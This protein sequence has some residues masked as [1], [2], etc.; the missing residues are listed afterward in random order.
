[1]YPCEWLI[2]I[3]ACLMRVAHTSQTVGGLLIGYSGLDIHFGE[4]VILNIKQN[5]N[6]VQIIFEHS[7]E[8]HFD[9]IIFESQ[10]VRLAFRNLHPHVSV[11]RCH[12]KLQLRNAWLMVEITQTLNHEFPERA[13]CES[14]A[15][16]LW[17]LCE[18]SVSLLW[19][20]GESSA[21]PL[22]VLR[23]SSVSPL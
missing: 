20:L 4:I 17:V 6:C 22:W 11:V 1:M 18:S 7:L 13:L 16:R 5:Y 15:S 8:K 23:E 19:V 2:A 10:V 14:S 3:P 9:R 21:S 12:S